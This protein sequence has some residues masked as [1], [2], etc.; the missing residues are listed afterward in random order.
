MQTRPL[1][2]K[3]VISS[4]PHASRPPSESACYRFRGADLSSACHDGCSLIAGGIIAFYRRPT[5]QRPDQHLIDT[6]PVGFYSLFFSR[7]DSFFTR[8]PQNQHNPNIHPVPPTHPWHRQES[9]QPAYCTDSRIIRAG[10]ITPVARTLLAEHHLVQARHGRFASCPEGAKSYRGWGVAGHDP[11]R[12][13]RNR[14]FPSPCVP[15][16]PWFKIRVESEDRT[17]EDTEHTDDDGDETPRSLPPGSQ[18]PEREAVS[19]FAGDSGRSAGM[20]GR[21]RGRRLTST[22][23]SHRILASQQVTSQRR[24]C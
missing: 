15:Y 2:H 7:V 13:L 14:P 21:G 10:V 11:R 24:W 22:E 19:R 18:P 23:N 20:L 9:E 5:C 3:Q 6:Q 8:N 4:Q 16:V 1:S 17:T 12:K